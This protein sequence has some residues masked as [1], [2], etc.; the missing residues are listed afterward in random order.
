MKVNK[1][2]VRNFRSITKEITIE[3][4]EYTSIVGANNVGKSNVLNALTLSLDLV[5][6]S[7]YRRIRT[8]KGAG[9][10]RNDRNQYIFDRDIPV[11][12]KEKESAHTVFQITFELTPQEREDLKTEFNITLNKDITL[13]F[14]FSVEE[15]T[16]DILMRGKANKTF[17]TNKHK[18]AEFI[19]E[20]LTYTYIPCVR[21]T[22][23]SEDYFTDTFE[24]ALLELSTDAEYIESMKIIQKKQDEI[25]E[26][27]EESITATVSKFIP[28]VKKVYLSNGTAITRTSRRGK[29]FVDDGSDTELELKGDGIKS[30]T[31]I[32]LKTYV[33][34]NDNSNSIICIEEPEAHLHSAAIYGIKKILQESLKN[35]QVIVSTHS[36]ILVDKHKASNNWI[37]S[38]E[39]IKK[40]KNLIEIKQSLGVQLTE[41]LVG[42]ELILLVEGKSDE[43]I[44]KK[45]LSEEIDIDTLCENNKIKIV[46]LHGATKASN[47]I[48]YYNSL[49]MSLHILLDNDDCGLG[50]RMKLTA[51]GIIEEKDITMVT[52]ADMKKSEIED[53]INIDTYNQFILDSYAVD[54]KSSPKFNEKKN[55][56]SVRI[57]NAFM[58]QGQIYNQ[59]IE[60]RIKE[61][62]ASIVESMGAVVL[63]PHRR[64]WLLALG[65]GIK[66][67]LS[68]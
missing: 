43:R 63:Y 38:S 26:K 37:V 4:G 14:D 25:L 36:P 44:I 55:E 59:E 10:L 47:L 64:N 53:M 39:G 11:N 12:L 67:K 66:N 30:L 16:Y 51:S 6:T 1:F 18:I 60:D 62:I 28:D 33:A 9:A 40:C 50:E 2:K 41:E 22:Q 8:R 42:T 32:A 61:E 48:I 57:K 15:A 45:L 5:K 24:R 65:R 23:I 54:L 46:N 3:L 52:C 31:A 7:S 17:N 27:V 56:W 13:K 19:A 34:E 35:Y 58:D 29:I 20:H 68:N 49:L 21:P